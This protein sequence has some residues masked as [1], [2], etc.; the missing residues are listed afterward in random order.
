L[1]WMRYAV[2]LLL[3]A[4]G[5]SACAQTFDLSAQRVPQTEL[6][7][8]WR[9]HPGEDASWASPS[10]DDSGRALLFAM[11]PLEREYLWFGHMSRRSAVI[12]V[13]CTALSARECLAVS[14]RQSRWRW[15]GASGRMTI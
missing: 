3:L 10:L 8:Q 13:S 15:R 5:L 6:K 4:A 12:R 2:T 11:R 1:R 9:F 7:R 14:L